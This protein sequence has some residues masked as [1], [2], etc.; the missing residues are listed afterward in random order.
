LFVIA[1][2]AR[3]LALPF[4]VFDSGDS[5]TRVWLAWQWLENPYVITDGVWGPLHFYMLAA[6]LSLWPD[7]VWAPIAL[8]VALGSLV[9]VVV[10][11]IAL[12]WFGDWRAAF[13]AGLAFCVY[14]MAIAVSVLPR[15]ETPFV[16]FLG[17]ALLFLARA[18]RPER[19]LRDAILA[20][21]ALG[22]ATMLRYEA[23]F[24]M[25]FLAALLLDRPK[26]MVAFLIPALL[27]PAF[28]MA[29]NYLVHHDPFYSIT[30][31]A[32]WNRD[33]IGGQWHTDSRAGTVNVMWQFM[34]VARAGLSIPLAL[35]VAAGVASCLAYR[36]RAAIW[37][38]PPLG[39]FLMLGM[40]AGKGTLMVKP[41]YTVTFGILLIPYVAC[42]VTVLRSEQWSARRYAMAATAFVALIA[43]CT[44]EPLWRAAPANLKI[45][46]AQ[47]APHFRE[48][49][50]AEAVQELVATAH[51][52]RDDG[53]ISEFYGSMPTGYVALHTKLHPKRICTAPGGPHGE[54]DVDGVKDFVHRY[55]HGVLISRAEGRLT[56]NLRFTAPD[57]ARIEGMTL[58]VKPVGSVPW[59]FQ[60][61][62]TSGHGAV[63][64]ARY[65]LIADSHPPAEIERQ[66]CVQ[67]CTSQLISMCLASS[68]STSHAR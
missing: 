48:E 33:S 32:D 44:I 8:H 63:S 34:R 60:E 19:Q 62:D 35:A 14:P 20:G 13:I 51:L 38:L 64:V 31:A 43:V 52:E 11:Y 53:L 9:P 56:S 46:Y 45:F 50:G 36:R 66:R 59:A 6:M 15:S 17:L 16:L 23:W 47:A 67:P 2:G 7:P 65:E 41:Q 37:L 22:L 5:A 49:E 30:W 1:L 39:L 18:R 4:S 61:R 29:G 40:A 68:E 21:V 3:L 54:L 28:W 42:L 26:Q 12:E 27:H 58:R 24:L 57:T 55:P 25:P 10:Y